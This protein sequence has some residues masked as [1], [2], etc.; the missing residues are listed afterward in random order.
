M[1]KKKFNAKMETMFRVI[2]KLQMNNNNL[3]I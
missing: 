2:D 1:Y 3:L